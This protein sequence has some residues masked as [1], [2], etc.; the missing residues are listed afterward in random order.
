MVGYDEHYPNRGVK[1]ERFH[2]RN[3]C[4]EHKGFEYRYHE[5]KFSHVLIARRIREN[6]DY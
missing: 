3:Y 4:L 5:K 6:A 2:R 1:G